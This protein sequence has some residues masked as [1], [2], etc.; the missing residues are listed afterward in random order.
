MLVLGA[1]YHPEDYI[2]TFG[3]EQNLL[4][5]QCSLQNAL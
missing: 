3:E 1:V 5:I 4:R 2:V